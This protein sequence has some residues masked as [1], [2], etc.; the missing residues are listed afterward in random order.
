VEALAIPVA[1][2]SDRFIISFYPM[3]IR[4]KSPWLHGYHRRP[5]LLI[6]MRRTGAWV[7]VTA[8]EGHT[9]T[10]EDVDHL[11]HYSFRSIARDRRINNRDGESCGILLRGL[12]TADPVNPK[13]V[14]FADGKT[15]HEYPPHEVL[16][17]ICDPAEQ[18]RNWYH[19]KPYVL[20]H[21]L[22]DEPFT[23]HY[24]QG[25]PRQQDPGYENWDFYYHDM[26]HGPGIFSTTKWYLEDG[27]HDDCGAGAET[28]PVLTDL[29][30]SKRR[31]PY[32]N[33]DPLGR[34]KRP[35][36]IT[37]RYAAGDTI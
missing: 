23:L 19:D 16:P 25:N 9:P 31:Y 7:A 32:K 30:R 15:L 37:E 17:P 10:Y 12:R 35:F 20:Y 3:F 6:P 5:D 36:D 13:F 2:E 22:M 8:A 34:F 18:I 11:Y 24:N 1:R 27:G 28:I 21:Y 4:A 14:D 26:Q 29:P 33:A